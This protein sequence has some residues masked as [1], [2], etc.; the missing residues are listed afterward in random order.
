MAGFSPNLYLAA[1]GP[2]TELFG[3]IIVV[4]VFALL[5]SQAD[6]RPYFRTWEKSWV[7][8]AV[9]LTAGLFYERFVDPES[10]FYPASPA[11]TYFAAAAFLGMRLLAVAC[12]LNGI[13]LY[14]RGAEKKWLVAASIGVAVVLAIAIDTQRTPLAPLALWHGP[15]TAIAYGFGAWQIVRLPASRQGIGTRLTAIGLGSLALLSVSLAAFYLLQRMAPDITT[16][17]WLIRFARYGFYSEL[18]LQFTLAWAMIRLLI[19]DGRHEADDTRAHMKL[20]QDRDTLGDLYDS[21]SRI[22]GRRAFDAQL[23]LGFARASFGTVALMKVANYQ[24]VAAEHSAGVA[25]ALV[26]N[27]AGVLDSAVRAHDRVYRWSA[28]E[29]MIVMPRAVPQVARARVEVLAARAA[30]LSISGSREPLRA[31]VAVAVQFYEGGDELAR[32]AA[33]VARG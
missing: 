7:F 9:S 23:G 20:I 11:T 26:A 24:R 19:E 6:R 5:R 1:L 27:L 30:P 21:A 4:A 15:I 16:N 25:E 22:L 32:A 17:P 10:V 8:L 28:D 31:D 2:L 12:V 29:L 13:S 33:N 14:V 18:I 3:V